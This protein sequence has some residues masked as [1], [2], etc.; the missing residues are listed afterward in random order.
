MLYCIG[1]NNVVYYYA[2]RAFFRWIAPGRRSLRADTVSAPLRKFS[3]H[4]FPCRS[5]PE[6]KRQRLN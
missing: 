6:T 3:P 5:A 1:I 4:L 2:Y